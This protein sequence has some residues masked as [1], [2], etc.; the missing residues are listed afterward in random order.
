MRMPKIFG[1]PHCLNDVGV[2]LL[3][4]QSLDEVGVESP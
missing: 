1:H 4:A 2:G 3:F